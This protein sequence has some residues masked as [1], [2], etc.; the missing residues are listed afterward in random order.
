MLTMNSKP[1]VTKHC[2]NLFDYFQLQS[3]NSKIIESKNI[4]INDLVEYLNMSGADNVK[5]LLINVASEEL[6][7]IIRKAAENVIISNERAEIFNLKN[8]LQDKDQ[9]INDLEDIIYELQTSHRSQTDRANKLEKEI[10]LILENKAIDQNFIGNNSL[11]TNDAKVSKRI[12]TYFSIFGKTADIKQSLVL[13]TINKDD[14]INEKSKDSF[15]EIPLGDNEL[16]E[17]SDNKETPLI[18]KPKRF[19][20]RI[21]HKKEVISKSEF[22]SSLNDF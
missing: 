9:H 14:N 16:K 15:E 7:D 22:G 18:T 8:Q 1:E 19:I 17:E 6:R 4:N 2:I 10:V 13:S 5:S 20:H 11:N 3:K 21:V 12:G